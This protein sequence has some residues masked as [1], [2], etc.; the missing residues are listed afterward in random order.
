MK[1]VV[2]RVQKAAV[3]SGETVIGSIGHGLLLLVGIH[4]DDEEEMVPWAGRKIVKMRIFDDEEGKMNRSVEDVSGEILVVSQFT[5]LG[6]ASR[7][8]RP[9]YSEAA[10]PEKAERLYEQLTDWLK[11]HSEGKVETGSFGNHMKVSLVND[12]PVTIILER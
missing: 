8:N 9:G 11:R 2:Q 5:L 7:G 12:G 3:E 4:R 1:I 10:S 6:D